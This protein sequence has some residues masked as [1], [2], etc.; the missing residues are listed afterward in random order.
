MSLLK[1]TNEQNFE[2]DVINTQGI[3]VV[4]FWAEWCMPCKRL[5][6]IL[7]AVAEQNKDVS[8]V[9]I[10]VDE[11]PDLASTFNIR[12][13]PTLILF[14]EGKPIATKNGGLPAIEL[15]EWIRTHK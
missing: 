12:T 10:N 14:K 5:M 7:E 11:N 13:I 8:I 9:K 2:N 3:T 6:P 4:D 15:N 1:Y